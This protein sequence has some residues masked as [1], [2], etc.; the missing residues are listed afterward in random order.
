MV[1]TC[2][3]FGT[4]STFLSKVWWTRFELAFPQ[5]LKMNLKKPIIKQSSA[6][7]E[8]SI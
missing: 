1:Y 4:Y 3:N 7:Y 6:N 5:H 8:L 2:S